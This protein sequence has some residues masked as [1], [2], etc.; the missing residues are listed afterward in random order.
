MTFVAEELHYVF[1]LEIPHSQQ[2]SELIL[3]APH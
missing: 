2:Q 3:L 1:A